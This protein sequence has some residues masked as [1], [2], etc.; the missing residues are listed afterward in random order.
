MFLRHF[1]R[2]S[3]RFSLINNNKLYE[4]SAFYEKYVIKHA[5]YILTVQKN[6]RGCGAKMLTSVC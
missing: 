4:Y 5:D 2:L 6:K 3:Y 1:L